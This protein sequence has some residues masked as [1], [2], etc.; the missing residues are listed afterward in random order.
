MYSKKMTFFGL[1]IALLI[2]AASAHAQKLPLKTSSEQARAALQKALQLIDTEQNDKALAE[3]DKALAADPDFAMALAVKAMLSGRSGNELLEKALAVS[4]GVEKEFITALSLASKRKAEEAVEKLQ[5]LHKKLPDEP[6]VLMR[7]G[8]LQLQRGEYSAAAATFEAANKLTGGTPLGRS[9]Y[10]LSKGNESLFNDK[11]AEARSYYQ[12]IVDA[13]D[14]DATPFIPF[15]GQVYAHVYESAPEKAI[16]V[17]DEYMARYNRNGAAQGY[18]PTWIW[19]MRARINLEFG[20]AEEA[21]RNYETG[22]KSVPPSQLDSLQKE[23]WLGR[24][25]HGVARSLAKMGQTERAWQ[26]AEK[27]RAQLEAAGEQGQRFMPAYH[28]LAGY[29]KLEAGELDAAIEHLKQANQRDAFILLL[30]ARAYDR[31]GDKENAL[32][33]YQNILK[34]RA[35]NVVRALAYPE[36]KKMVAQ[37]TSK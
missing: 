11:Y 22:Y 4:E 30:L 34:V 16:A 19:N 7:L 29:I 17:I 27:M 15:F 33:A 10:W 5:A 8:A 37:L 14:R 2:T 23:I 1:L 25:H 32:A 13:G 6:L 18:P 20:N 9:Q 36:A 21:L 12:K 26:I 3:L 35:N 28:Y 31:N 24:K